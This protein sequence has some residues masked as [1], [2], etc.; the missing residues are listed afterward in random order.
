MIKLFKP[1]TSENSSFDGFFIDE[2]EDIN[3][4]NES[5]IM[6][7]DEVRALVQRYV[8]AVKQFDKID[9]IVKELDYT[10]KPID[11]SSIN[12]SLG[13]NDIITSK[14]A[15][16]KMIQKRSWKYIFNKMN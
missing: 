13:Y 11:V 15:F 8:G 1:Q 3:V 12:L 5:G 16:A 6:P 9:D 4:N 2:D 7:F 14:E 10:L